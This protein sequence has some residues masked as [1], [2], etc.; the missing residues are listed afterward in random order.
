[1]TKQKR[2]KRK[3]KYRTLN[4]FIS[5]VLLLVTSFLLYTLY[6]SD[7]LGLTY[8]ILAA[9]IIAIIDLILMKL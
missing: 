3:K 2:R 6:K 1:M 5:V 4:L 9:G 8:F 7:M